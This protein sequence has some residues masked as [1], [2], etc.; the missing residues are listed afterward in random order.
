VN[1]KYNLVNENLNELENIFQVQ[2]MKTD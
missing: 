2:S 1:S